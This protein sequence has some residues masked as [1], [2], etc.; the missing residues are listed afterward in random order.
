MLSKLLTVYMYIFFCLCLFYNMYLGFVGLGFFCFFS[1]LNIYNIACIMLTH[2][3]GKNEV[4]QNCT[5]FDKAL[6]ND[7]LLR[8]KGLLFPLT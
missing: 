4:E 1:F 5:F 6:R 7:F 8:V 2:Y 3:Q